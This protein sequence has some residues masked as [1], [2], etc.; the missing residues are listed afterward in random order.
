LSKVNHTSEGIFKEFLRGGSQL[1][2][3]L[4]GLYAIG[5]T[6]ARYGLS[7]N[8]VLS[9]NFLTLLV[10]AVLVGFTLAGAWE[11]LLEVTLRRYQYNSTWKEGFVTPFRVILVEG[12]VRFGLPLGFFMAIATTFGDN[13]ISSD[14]ILWL[15]FLFSLVFYL[16]G[17]LLVGS[18]FG[19]LLLRILKPLVP[20]VEGSGD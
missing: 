20:P 13:G 10:V 2:I 14:P 12:G 9:V 19:F 18:V 11:V 17:F 3:A 5:S 4:G 6:I 7:T 15:K 8:S 1:G 16:P